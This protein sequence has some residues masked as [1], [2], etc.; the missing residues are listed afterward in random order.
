MHHSKNVEDQRSQS[1]RRR[2]RLVADGRQEREDGEDGAEA[3][4]DDAEKTILASAS[5]ALSDA[6]DAD[7]DGEKPTV[8][9][10]DD[11]AL[12]DEEAEG[13]EEDQLFAA[14][15]GHGNQLDRRHLQVD[16]L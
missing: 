4:P 7:A 10:G 5:P 12:D 9:E 6:N 1:H 14:G 11:E 15:L 16:E 3:D 2:V 8:E 13:Q